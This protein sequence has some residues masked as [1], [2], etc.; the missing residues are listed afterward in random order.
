MRASRCSRNRFN[1]FFV[2]VDSLILGE[3]LIHSL[4]R[5]KSKV[6]IFTK[7]PRYGVK[8]H[9]VK[10]AETSFVLKLII[11]TGKYT[12]Y[13]NDNTYMLNTVKVVCELCKPF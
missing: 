5:I 3:S 9:V 8:I 4:G 1:E 10:Y 11:Y 2:P 6:I 13:N 12:Y 7:I